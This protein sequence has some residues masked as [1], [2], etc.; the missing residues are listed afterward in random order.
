M[1][2]ASLFAVSLIVCLIS[3]STIAA[4]ASEA[5]SPTFKT[6]YHCPAGWFC[7]GPI[8]PGVGGICRLLG[9]GEV[10]LA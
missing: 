10:C 2:K 3:P 8:I 5:V 9:E 7:C 4:S 1:F 6:D